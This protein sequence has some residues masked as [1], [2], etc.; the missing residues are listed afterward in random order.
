MSTNLYY[1]YMWYQV[2]TCHSETAYLS[3]KV[4]SGRTQV[5]IEVNLASMMK[6]PQVWPVFDF[7][8]ELF[9]WLLWLL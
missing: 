2:D 4:W 1:V 9:Q 8:P 7:A 6:P 3:L 5:A